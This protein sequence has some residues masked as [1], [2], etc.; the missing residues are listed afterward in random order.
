MPSISTIVR[1]LPVLGPASVIAKA[2]AFKAAMDLPLNVQRT[3]VAR[4]IEG[5]GQTLA[6]DT[7]MLLTLARVET[8][9]EDMTVPASRM[10]MR[11]QAA[12]AGGNQKIGAIEDHWVNGQKA[13]LYIP[14]K[15]SGGR[16]LLVYI[17][18]GGFVCGDV[19]S[20]DPACRMLAE[21]SGVRVLSVEYRLA[22]EAPFPAAYEDV[23]TAF[24][25]VVGH[26]E[27]FGADPKRIGVGGDSAGGNLAANVALAVGRKCAFQLL[28]Y[29]VTDFTA[30]FASRTLFGEGFYLTKPL[31]EKW[32]GMY[33]PPGI[34][35]STDPRLSPLFA[36]VRKTTAPAFVVTAGF[37]PLRDEGE[38]YAHKLEEAGIDVDFVRYE[39]LIHGFF[40]I[41]GAGHTAKAAVRDIAGV[42]SIKLG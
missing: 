41:V 27:E 28:I 36:K 38:A 32:E 6:P 35:D 17:H 37:D 24:E 31:M 12:V 8:P 23:I 42:L 20:H 19:E 15:E 7:Q 3:L 40:N 11:E 2:V 26:A 18:G 9:L 10:A 14:T 30:S 1:H 34:V 33:A 4:P 29:P 25:Y 22:P 16:G 39:G 5:D 13:R 21:L